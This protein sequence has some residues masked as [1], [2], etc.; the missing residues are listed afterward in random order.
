MT[1]KIILFP[2]QGCV[3]L[4]PVDACREC[5]PPAVRQLLA[6]MDA[7]ES[8]FGSDMPPK[9]MSVE[10]HLQAVAPYLV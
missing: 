6:I 7:T 5:L 4:V 1:A 10:E 8:A 2:S 9:G 3:H